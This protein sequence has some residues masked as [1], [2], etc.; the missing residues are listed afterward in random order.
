MQLRQLEMTEQAER[1]EGA[2]GNGGIRPF[3]CRRRSRM[4]DE[5]GGREQKWN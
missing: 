2:S 5:A 1:A 4:P 3:A